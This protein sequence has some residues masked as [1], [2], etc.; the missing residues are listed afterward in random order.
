MNTIMRKWFMALSLL[1][2]AGLCMAADKITLP[3]RFERGIPIVELQIGKNNY[4]FMLDTGAS[5]KIYV[6][7]ADAMSKPGLVR[8]GKLLKS[9]NIS[10]QVTK[11]EELVVKD[12]LVNGMSFGRT[13]GRFCAERGTDNGASLQGP[14]DVSVLGISFFK[15]RK[16]FFDFAAREVVIFDETEPNVHDWVKLGY[17]RIHEGIIIINLSSLNETYY[18]VLDSASTISLVNSNKV[19]P[20]ESPNACDSGSGPGGDACRKI[21]VGLKEEPKFAAVLMELPENFN[22]DGL[23]GRAFF[24]QYAVFLDIPNRSIRVRSYTKK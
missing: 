13:E 7:R 10:G 14:P 2:Y 6:T 19:G 23:V 15:T 9:I 17:V 22:A 3:L 20:K 21:S 11:T 8:T 5:E 12:L 24:D 18:M 4:S 1:S 16:S